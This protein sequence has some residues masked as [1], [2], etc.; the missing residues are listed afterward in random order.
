MERASRPLVMVDLDDTLFQ[1]GRKIEPAE[2][3]A[4]AAR[5]RDGRPICY[6]SRS[7]Q[8][9][10]EW[11][12]DNAEVVPVTARSVEAFQRVELPFRH[13]AICSHGAVILNALGEVDQPWRE[14][15]A[16]QL[17]GWQPLLHS[18]AE[19]IDQIATTDRLPLRHWG[20]VES[21][22]TI[23]HV[24]KQSADNDRL[25]DLVLDRIVAREEFKPF[26]IH[27][28]GNNLALMP[29]PLGKAA[30]VRE[31]LQRHAGERPLLA[32]GDSLTDL[33]F[34]QQCHWWATPTGSQIE[35]VFDGET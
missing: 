4:T 10:V 11:L 27:Q 5:D 12:I 18:V 7:Q 20:V 31:W 19:A 26:Q 21:D 2:R 16:Q 6:L 8:L 1:S 13:G 3:A 35:R 28:N 33:P 9:F 32:F 25:L 30:A 23:Y 24:V 14:R 22:L 17:A 29:P 15:M 34:M